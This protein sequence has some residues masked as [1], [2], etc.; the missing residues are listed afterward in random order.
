ME[1]D[2]RAVLDDVVEIVKHIKFRPLNARMF[3]LLC[4]EMGSEHTTVLLRTEL[5][6]LYRGKVLVMVFELRRKF[7]PSSLSA[8]FIFA[9]VW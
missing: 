7:I 8:H 4:Q 9:S 6:W 5:T 1:T 2:S 3:K